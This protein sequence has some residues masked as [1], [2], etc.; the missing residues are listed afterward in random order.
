MFWWNLNHYK[1]SAWLPFGQGLYI[2]TALA[3][4]KSVNAYHLETDELFFMTK[5]LI[6][7]EP[8]CPAKKSSTKLDFSYFI[9]IFRFLHLSFL[10]SSKFLQISFLIFDFFKISSN[11]I[12]HFWFLQISFFQLSKI[13]SIFSFSNY[14][15]F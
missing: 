1:I 7:S 5:C 14:F 12:S 2:T 10:I 4:K 9:L 13:S 11:L 3:K 8:Q 15:N 6:N